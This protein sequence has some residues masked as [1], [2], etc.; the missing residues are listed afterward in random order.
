MEGLDE[1]S[2]VVVWSLSGVVGVVDDGFRLN[3]AVALLSCGEALLTSL[4]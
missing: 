2:L 1:E 3:R 4:N